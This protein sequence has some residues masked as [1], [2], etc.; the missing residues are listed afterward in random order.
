[1]MEERGNVQRPESGK[2]RRWDYAVDFAGGDGLHGRPP[3]GENQVMSKDTTLPA[4]SGS[5]LGEISQAPPALD[6]FLDKH[7]AKLIV[8]SLII[9]LC[10]IAYVVY[11]GIERSAQETA[12]ALLSKAGDVSELQ[13]VVKNHEG[14]A[15]AESAKILLAEKQWQEGQQE[16]AIATLETYVAGDAGH[17]ARPSALASLA[18]KLLAQGK[19]DEASEKFQ[20]ITDDPAARYLAPY[21]WI[22]LGD[23]NLSKGDTDAAAKAYETVEREF[24]DSPFSRDAMQ[25]RLLMKATPP[26]EVPAPITVPDVSLIDNDGEADPADPIPGNL[27]EA[28]KGGGIDPGANP[29]Q[30]TEEN[31]E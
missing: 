20:E 1:M 7:Q 4:S 27:R 26:T 30:P 19:T 23:I 2:L 9:A 11:E 22:S 18:A 16:D 28:T 3:V 10:A 31:P 29:L 6:V 13:E 24:P 5:P 12:G 25:R 15:A 14:T 17:P 8:L 21:A